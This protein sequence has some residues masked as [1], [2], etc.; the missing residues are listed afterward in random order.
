MWTRSK[1][2]CGRAALNSAMRPVVQVLES[3]C[4]LS[5]GEYASMVW[6][7]REVVVVPN[8]WI[9]VME[10]AAPTYDDEGGLVDDGVHSVADQAGRD[11]GLLDGAK[12]G[13]QFQRY[14]G[15]EHMFTISAPATAT[16]EF[17]RDSLKGIA[18][19]RSIEP[20]QV[21]TRNKVPNDPSF[22]SQWHL[23]Q[24]SDA[25][26]DAPEAWDISTGSPGVAVAVIDSGVDLQHSDMIPSLWT[27]PVEIAGDGIDND[28]NGKIDDVRGWN[29]YGNNNNPD[30]TDG[31]G[32]AVAGVI[33]AKGNNGQATSGV[34]WASPIISLVD[35]A[36]VPQIDWTIS[37]IQY[38]S[39]LKANRGINVRVINIS[40]QFGAGSD[41]LSS[42]IATAGVNGILVVVAAG[43][44]GE[45]IDVTQSTPASYSLDNIIAVA[46]TTKIDT[47]SYYSNIG[48]INVDLAAPGDAILTLKNGG[49]TESVDGT[50]FSAPQVAGVAALA[51]SVNPEATYQQVKDAILGGVD[52]K[53][54]LT[55][56]VATGGRLNAYNTLVRMGVSA[57][58]LIV[59]GDLSGNPANDTILIRP[60]SNPAY[61]EV[62]I[63]GVQQP[64]R[65]ATSVSSIE[66]YGLGGN[67]NIDFS[68]MSRAVNAYGG[69]GNDTITGG[70]GAD[71]IYG[72]ND[73]DWLAGNDGVD[74]IYG[75]FGDDNL[76]GGLQGDDL[77][78][79][80]GNDTLIGGDGNDLLY[81]GDGT[82]S[83]RAGA[84]N[85]YVEGKGK[86]DTIYGSTGNDTIDAG[87]G[88]DL[89]YGEDG[90]DWIY[91]HDGVTLSFYD[92]VYGGAGYDR[93]Q[94]DA[95]DS[96]LEVEEHLVY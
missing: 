30:D 54:S 70:S 90:D 33:A 50:S 32:T 7:G 35:G 39:D 27:N 24:G 59:I 89:V 73:N 65:L 8:Q 5:G 23:S 84:G 71:L 52:L 21:G 29:F 66:V 41:A 95:W 36:A 3:R 18:G 96:V 81:G 91:V 43:N 40:S 37:A 15:A 16:Y 2:V 31:H 87:A 57:S 77:K 60:Y 92:T 61:I 49:G 85:D 42:V 67:D 51:F 4:Y 47:L 76:M 88:N 1:K 86:D 75:N 6:Q 25:D 63:N 26:I 72:G 44:D 53:S 38:V 19:F 56:K 20:V 94:W 22:G 68:G 28:G 17:L 58:T 45:N 69:N 11:Q 83:I 10:H 13:A 93:A 12:A 48:P 62:L 80:L 78:G 79:G 64:L 9:V 55:G 34:S 14:L 46:A 82:D 74:T